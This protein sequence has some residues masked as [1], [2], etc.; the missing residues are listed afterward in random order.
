M[1]RWGGLAGA[2]LL[3]L[4]V[5]G[6]ANAQ[7]K[8]VNVYNWTDYIGPHVIPGFEKETGIKVNYDTYDQNETLEAKLSAGNS[9]YD[10][11]V[12][13]FTPFLV[14]GA[15]IGLYQTLNKS[16]LKNWGNLDPEILQLMAKSDPGNKYA[17]PWIVATDGIAVNIEK[18]KAIMP[19]APFDSYDL[20]FKPEIL[21][22]F[23]D[24]GVEMIDSP[25]DELPV[26]LNWLKLDPNSENP[27]DIKRA[28]A[29]MTS[30]RPSIRKFE[31]SGYIN[32]LAN[33]DIC[34]AFGYS[35]DIK[36]AAKR[37]KEAKKPFHIE[38]IIP[39]EGTLL[40]LDAL[41]IPAGAP[42][43][44]DAHAFI[45]YVMRPDVMADTA[46]TVGGRSGNAAALP[47]ILPEIAK[48]PT[49]YPP[50]EVRKTFFVLT[51]TSRQTEKLRT[52]LWT[53]IKTGL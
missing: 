41:A 10:V 39:R 20:I 49:I 43:V 3:A 12:P 16:L 4:G 29:V 21:D 45:D 6:A 40:Y 8:V 9:G 32:D 7:Q 28:A 42:H 53:K 47:Y 36:I 11:A 18:V 1:A 51:V 33:G 13:T 24:C 14:R 34:I 37:A 30:I 38:Y 48:D 31:S 22:K 50:P 44:A 35:T 19:D 17:V 27:D 52:R 23:K 5:A 15:K 26:I 2:I 46:N 25:T